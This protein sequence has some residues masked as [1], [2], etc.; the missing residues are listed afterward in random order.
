M[1]LTVRRE[2]IARCSEARL[3]PHLCVLEEIALSSVNGMDRPP[4][5]LTSEWVRMAALQSERED[6]P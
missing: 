3:D 6:P 5:K 2:R 1:Y 4:Q